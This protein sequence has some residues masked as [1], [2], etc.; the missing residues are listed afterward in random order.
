MYDIIRF[1]VIFWS[2]VLNDQLKVPDCIL[3]GAEN[4]RLNS[5]QD[6]FVAAPWPQTL[7]YGLHSDT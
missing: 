5:A 7:T 6:S 1:S 3:L 4:G 2:V